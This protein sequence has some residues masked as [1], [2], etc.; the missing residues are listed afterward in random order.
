MIDI[1]MVIYLIMVCAVS[2]I[3]DWKKGKIYNKWLGMGMCPGAVIVI[4]YYLRGNGNIQLFL[5]N[6]LAA[7]VIA[8]IFYSMK[9]WGAGDSKLWLFVN[10]LYPTEWYVIT[11]TML[12]PSMILF[13]VI[14]IE[15]YIY[16]IGESLWYKLFRHE[17]GVKFEQEKINGD[18]I[19]NLSFSVSFLSVVYMVLNY[20]LKEYY[21]GNRIFFSVVGILLTN[22][23]VSV[24]FRGKKIWTILMATGYIVFSIAVGGGFDAKMLIFTL[25]LVL[26]THFSLKFADQY[27]Y[28]WIKTC[29]VK[30]GMILSYFTIQQF[31]GSRVKGLP[32]ETD[33]S[34]KSRISRDEADAIKRW[35]K[36]KYGQEKIMV[37]RYIP[38]AVFILIGILTYWIGVYL[39]K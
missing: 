7:V 2:A 1:I 30:E 10:F 15:A 34:T 5:T 27:N 35:E 14:F 22:K 21:E 12:F 26:I 6:F 24:K 38:F 32:S 39:L 36:S 19:W 3:T 29:D 17:K 25:F 11:N 28:E 4:Y 20:L 8:I 16:L 33:E 23:L 18:Q 9:L 31:Y 13:M 37:V